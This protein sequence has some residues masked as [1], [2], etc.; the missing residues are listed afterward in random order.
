MRMRVIPLLVAGLL[1]ASCG[2]GPVAADEAQVEMT[3][4]GDGT[5]YVG[6]RQIIEGTVTVMFSNESND[7]LMLDVFGYETGSEGLAEELAF[8]EEG[9]RGVPSGLPAT[10]FYGVDYDYPDEL[11]PGSHTWTMDLAPGTYV[12]DA[13]AGAAFVDGL[14]RVAVIE[15]VAK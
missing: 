15:V 10:G 1:V 2:G 8:L 11:E 5:S 9:N 4:T 6:D 12:F 3:F 14:W 13:S 7:P